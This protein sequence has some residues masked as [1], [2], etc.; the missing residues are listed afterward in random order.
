MLPLHTAYQEQRR[1]DT[2][3]Q[4]CAFPDRYSGHICR[5]ASNTNLGEPVRR[6]AVHV[7]D[8]LQDVSPAGRR[9]PLHDTTN[10][11]RVKFLYPLGT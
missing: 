1:S 6:T 2:R 10:E 8:E 7:A 9:R 11:S 3:P 4:H 5:I